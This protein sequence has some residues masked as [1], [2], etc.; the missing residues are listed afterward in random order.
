MKNNVAEKMI[1]IAE[2]GSLKIE[3]VEFVEEW[4]KWLKNPR[5]WCISR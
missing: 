4:K 5:D 2:N 3:P 1:E